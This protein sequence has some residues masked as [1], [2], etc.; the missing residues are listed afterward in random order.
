M[1]FNDSI[2]CVLDRKGTDVF[3]VPLGAS[4]YFCLREMA[5]RDVGALLVTENGRPVGIF[6]ERN[7]ARN[8]V[9]Q[10]RSSP[11]TLVED[12]MSPASCVSASD[13][14]DSCL[15]LMTSARVRHLVV[16]DGV[17]IAGVV[18]IGDLVSWMISTQ[19]ETIDHLTSYIAIGYPG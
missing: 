12:V 7:Y 9:L 5:R 8:V 15:H 11:E 18:S 16:M 13:S 19:A 4:V 6:S 2:R 10:G 1:K 17:A 14:I 3:S